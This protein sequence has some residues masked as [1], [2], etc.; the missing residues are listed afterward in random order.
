MAIISA[1]FGLLGQDGVTPRRVQMVV[2]DSLATVTTPE[3][4]L[5]EQLLPNVVYPTD[6]FD[7]IYATNS[8]TQAGTYGQFTP[9]FANGQITLLKT[10]SDLLWH[11]L[12]ITE[13][14][15]AS[16]AKVVI[17]AAGSGQQFKVRDIRVNYSSAGLSGSS[18][19]RLLA[20]TD[21]TT[22]FNNAGIT[23]ALLGTPI[24]TLWGGTGNPLPG[25]VAMN[26]LSV[27]GASIYAQYAGGTTDYSAGSISISI[28][29]QQ[30]A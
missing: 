10:Y 13:A 21:G 5:P 7:I 6:I 15:L 18:G 2:T 29:L 28:L 23:A 30:V 8:V 17:Q 19:N 27:A 12:V 26:T 20:I 9:V 11:D 4:L 25:A 14:Q 22:A 16:A 3:Y 1:T 24:N